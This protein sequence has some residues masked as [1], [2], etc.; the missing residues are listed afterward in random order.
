MA[1]GKC[2]HHSSQDA[3]AQCVGCGKA[4]CKD[5]H[6]VYGVSSGQY[7]GKALCYD[8]TSKLVAENM[9]EVEA[10]KKKV[11]RERI[12]SLI[13]AAI[14]AIWFFPLLKRAP[15]H[16]FGPALFWYFVG[17][18]FFSSLGVI[19]TVFQLLKKDSYGGVILFLVC[20]PIIT[21][22]NHIKRFTQIKQADEII[23][24][25]AIALREM[26]DYF[27]YTQVMEKQSD[28]LDL[29]KLTGQGSELYDNTYA[30]AVLGKGEKAAQAELRKSVVQIAANG[31]IIR[32]FD[33]EPEERR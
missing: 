13:G 6:D 19:K 18:A 22:K 4:I 7:V 14:A 30:K 29:A 8:C 31:E 10:F 1:D 21:I 28:A 5:C 26:R 15:A 12:F 33:E 11:Q 32:S 23:A 2:Y 17:I 24:S 16:D 20:A 3:V 9:A 27:A 25:D